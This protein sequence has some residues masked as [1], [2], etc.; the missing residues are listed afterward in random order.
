[1]STLLKPP[2]FRLAS[3]V[4]NQLTLASDGPAVAH[5]FVLEDDII[6]VMVLPGG[7]LKHPRTW[8]VARGGDDVPVEGRDRFDLSGFTLPDFALDEADGML[9]VR[10]AGLRL[11]IRLNGLFCAWK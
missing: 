8:T 1:M 5:V 7:A 4:G 9:R 10:T 11:S 2:V 6:R 3:R